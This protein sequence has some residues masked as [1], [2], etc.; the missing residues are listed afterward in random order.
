MQGQPARRA[1]G[2]AG[3]ILR[4]MFFNDIENGEMPDDI[5]WTGK[6]V[7]DICYNNA[8]N[9]FGFDKI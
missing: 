7:Q 1:S 2:F 8:K 9:Y 4:P 5:E 3:L 6:I